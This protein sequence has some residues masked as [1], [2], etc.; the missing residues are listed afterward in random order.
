MYDII[1]ICTLEIPIYHIGN[2][3]IH[4]YIYKYKHIYIYIHIHTYIHIYIYIHTVIIFY[5]YS[6]GPEARHLPR[7]DWR[8]SGDVASPGWAAGIWCNSGSERWRN[9]VE[10]NRVRNESSD[11]T[12]AKMIGGWKQAGKPMTNG[13]TYGKPMETYLL[14]QVFQWFLV[15][16][17]WKGEFSTDMS[18][19]ISAEIFGEMMWNQ[20]GNGE[21]W[22]RP[23]KKQLT[24]WIGPAILNSH[25]WMKKL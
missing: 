25:C 10:K 7:N 5:S 11:E 12:D 21:D 20:S 6:F 3:H 22:Q 15:T 2:I 17:V 24:C 9:C 18:G 8:P 16:F 14:L 4:I 13:K 23:K 1:P 19:P